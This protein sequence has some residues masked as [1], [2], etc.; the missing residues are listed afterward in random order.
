VAVGSGSGGGERRTGCSPAWSRVS[1][2]S[3]SEVDILGDA[4]PLG[5]DEG[6]NELRQSTASPTVVMVAWIAW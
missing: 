2:R 5:G 3:G 1:A 4:G 6:D